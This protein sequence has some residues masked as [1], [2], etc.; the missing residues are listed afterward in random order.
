MNI[1]IIEKIIKYSRIQIVLFCMAGLLI[2]QGCTSV[3]T[4]PTVARAG[5]TVSVMVGGTEKA[6]KETIEVTLTDVNGLDWDLQALG[7]V[8]SVFNLRADGRADGTH[9]STYIES[10]ISWFNGHEPVQTVLVINLPVDVP[11]GNA[12]LTVNPL[13]DDDSSGI[14]APYT[15]NIE[16]IPGTGSNDDFLMQ[17]ASSGGELAVDFS[18]LEPAPHAKISFGIRD[19]IVIGAASLVIDFDESIVN[20][21]DINVYVPETTVRGS[22]VTTGAFGDKQ[23]MVYWHQDGQQLFIDVVA[24][25]GIEQDYLMMYLMHPRGLSGL[26]GFN[27]ISSKIYDVSGS[28]IVLTPT[29]EYFP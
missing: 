13:V 21:D 26:P 20:A 4:F 3:A 1:L 12:Y 18:R 10:Y 29:L 25:Q 23:R 24:P 17:D 28:E 15:I 14:T 27:I 2:T 5:D 16:V 19:Y 8:R 6:R 11:A 9:Y 22:V 7:L